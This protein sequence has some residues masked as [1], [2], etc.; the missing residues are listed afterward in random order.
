MTTTTHVAGIELS[1][2]NIN[3]HFGVKHRAVSVNL[4]NRGITQLAPHTFDA[5]ENMDYLTLYSN[6]IPEI[7]EDLFSRNPKLY[8]IR[9]FNN[10]IAQ[11]HKNTLRGLHQLESFSI[12]SNMITYLDV[13]TFKD[14]AKLA[15]LWLYNNSLRE[16]PRNIFKH[17]KEMIRLELTGN[18]LETFDFDS[19]SEMKHLEFL[20]IGNNLLREIPYKQ[21]REWFPRLREVGIAGNNFNCSHLQEIM[22]EFENE[23]F[24]VLDSNKSRGITASSVYGIACEP[25]SAPSP[26]NADEFT[27]LLRTNSYFNGIVQSLNNRI[28]DLASQVQSNTQEI[29]ALR[30]KLE[31]D[32]AKFSNT[33]NQQINKSSDLEKRINELIGKQN[34]MSESFDGHAENTAKNTIELSM[35]LNV[36]QGDLTAMSQDLTQLRENQ[37]NLQIRLTNQDGRIVRLES[38][39]V[40]L[41]ACCTVPYEKMMGEARQ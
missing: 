33:S 36:Q 6:N 25:V 18:Q 4:Y 20:L 17:L 3:S 21:F 30:A 16:L 24:R 34:E 9:M 32:N 2:G 12:G 28:S 27:F 40:V 38:R 35:R 15:F 1:A 41:Q 14:N 7:P 11:F 26:E 37:S 10:K 19:L 22:E 39:I 29:A 5:F 13:D 8:Y 31:S 23:R